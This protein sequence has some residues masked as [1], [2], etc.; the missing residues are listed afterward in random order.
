MGPNG[1]FGVTMGGSLL[2]PSRLLQYD[3]YDCLRKSLKKKKSLVKH[4]K[5]LSNDTSAEKCRSFSECSDTD[6][7]KTKNGAIF[8]F[9]YFTKKKI[10]STKEHKNDKKKFSIFKNE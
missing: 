8:S 5:V 4:E 9:F 2:F 6:I 7:P 1:E 3:S 10:S